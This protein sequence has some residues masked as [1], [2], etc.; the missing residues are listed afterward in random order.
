MPDRERQAIA[1]ELDPP[2]TVLRPAEI[3]APILFCSP[4]SGRIYP[5]VL[6]ERSQLQADALR[7]SEDCFVDQLFAC[8]AEL[9]APMIAAHFP[10]AYLDVNREPYELDPELFDGVLPD[11]A[12]TRT[13]RVIG[14]L[15][16][17]A[18]VV[19]ENEAI[20]RERLPVAVAFERIEKLYRPFHAAVGGI[21]DELTETFGYCVLVDCHSMPSG[22]IQRSTSARP[23][24]VIGDRFGSSCDPRITRIVR[25]HL[26]GSGFKVQLNRPYAGG[27]ITEHYG[28]PFSA[29]HA[30]QIE[31]NRGL[32]LDEEI[33]EKSSG[34]GE[35]SATIAAFVAT[36]IDRIPRVFAARIA[37]E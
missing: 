18:R 35:L 28:R 1:V 13:M 7:K 25:Q 26:V 2:F 12:N 30:I 32:Y 21:L 34:Y 9:G 29:R 3:V 23:D 19:S 6:I 10:R 11:F 16:T 33:F 36:M 31:I 27:F 8:A 15:G 17:I 37:A 14:G 20:Y 4:H 22:A 24:F 5:S